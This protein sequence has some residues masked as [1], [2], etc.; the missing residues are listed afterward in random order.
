VLTS[1]PFLAIAVLAAAAAAQDVAQ[2][3]T[4]ERELVL[5][6]GQ[7]LSLAWSHDGRWVASGGACGEVLVVDVA[8][9]AVAH[10]FVASEQGIRGL[11]YAPDDT[12][13][14]FGDPDGDAFAVDAETGRR[15]GRVEPIAPVPLPE[16]LREV[17]APA[18]AAIHADGKRWACARNGQLELHDG[19]MLIRSVPLPHRV[20]PAACA[21]A[22]SGRF[23]AVAGPDGEVRVFRMADGGMV[24]LSHP[25][26]G[27]PI[28]HP[29]GPELALRQ[30]QPIEPGCWA[31]TPGPSWQR[32]N[33]V[34]L[35]SIDALLA[36]TKGLV[37]E[38][39]TTAHTGTNGDGI[40]IAPSPD[41]TLA[42]SIRWLLG[43]PSGFTTVH[44]LTRDGTEIGELDFRGIAFTATWSPVGNRIALLA[45]DLHVCSSDPL[46]E[47]AAIPG[48]WTSFAWLDG[49][50]VLLAER[51]ENGSS[52]VLRSVDAPDVTDRLPLP[53]A[54]AVEAVRVFANGTRAV[55]LLRGS[56]LVVRITR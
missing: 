55:L 9:G 3:L 30:S 40:P 45:T 46:A 24:Q 53:V 48:A 50:R 36:G 8:T 12:R 31:L 14:L 27:T 32:A 42:V 15:L 22:A 11:R 18:P 16:W 39:A 5:R 54:Q 6:G 33:V 26:R 41:G 37:R 34:Q 1:L 38:F 43:C 13:M 51:T 28:D 25:L 19:A 4:I 56:V 47:T 7:S 44:M 20:R 23:L 2:R 29:D 52:L 10:E 21:E 49:T 35:W 17:A